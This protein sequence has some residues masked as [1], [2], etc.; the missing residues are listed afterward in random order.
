[1]GKLAT[2]AGLALALFGAAADRPG[3]PDY[4]YVAAPQYDSAAWRSGR[5]RFP[6]GAAGM[7]VTAQGERQVA[8]GFYASLDP[9][10]S[11]HGL[12]ILFAGKPTAAGPWQIWETAVAGGAP[13][14]LTTADTDCIR[15]LYLPDR[16]SV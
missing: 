4:A 1:M 9:G 7:L 11:F 14:Q 8:A 12:R 2:T 5:E 10:I 6:A 15:P 13:R 16:T 3:T